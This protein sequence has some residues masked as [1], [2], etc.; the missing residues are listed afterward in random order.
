MKKDV[1]VSFKSYNKYEEDNTDKIE[2]LTKGNFFEKDGK[3]FKVQEE[4]NHF[5]PCQNDEQRLDILVLMYLL[6]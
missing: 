6:W 2:F 3:L 4:V 1:M 5:S